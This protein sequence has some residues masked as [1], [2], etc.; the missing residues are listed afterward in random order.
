MFCSLLPPP[1]WNLPCRPGIAHQAECRSPRLC[2]SSASAPFG[3]MVELSPIGPYPRP[4]PAEAHST[5][6][7]KRHPEK[8]IFPDSQESGGLQQQ[9][10]RYSSGCSESEAKV[11]TGPGLRRSLAYGLF[12]HSHF[13]L[14]LPSSLCVSNLSSLLKEMA[15]MTTLGLGLTLDPR[16]S[17]F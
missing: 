4:V 17:Y 6:I 5:L 13:C 9:N 2:V 8:L 11:S 10:L 15:T 14:C 16:V 12:S 7:Y 1:G 3:N